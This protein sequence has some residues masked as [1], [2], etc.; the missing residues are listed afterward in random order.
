MVLNTVSVDLE[1][2]AVVD[3]DIDAPVANTVSYLVV[4]P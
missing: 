3:F 2:D 4:V 1:V